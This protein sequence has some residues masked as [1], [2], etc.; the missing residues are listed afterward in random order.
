MSPYKVRV[1][2]VEIVVET[3]E[4]LDLIIHRYGL[5]SEADLPTKEIR[6]IKDAMDR[7]YSL[8]RQF[9]TEDEVGIRS[10]E[11]ADW[12][13]IKGRGLPSRL[14]AW[15]KRV[16]LRGTFEDIFERTVYRGQRGFRL[17]KDAVE[18]AQLLL[19]E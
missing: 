15:A 13:R 16:G 10:E 9:V 18:K 8:L 2:G 3:L 19:G 5:S 4:E 7:D 12:F 6:S 1:R 11:L 17:T 14:L